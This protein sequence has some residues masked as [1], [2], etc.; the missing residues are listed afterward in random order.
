MILLFRSD[1]RHV[2]KNTPYTKTNCTSC[3]Y[4]VIGNTCK[5]NIKLL[6]NNTLEANFSPPDQP[7][8]KIDNIIKYVRY[9]PQSGLTNDS[10]IMQMATQTTNENVLFTDQHP[11]YMYE[12]KSEMDPTRHLQDSNDAT[13]ENFF[14]RPIKVAEAEWGT[15]TQL[16]FS[17]NPWASYFENKRV[18]NRIANYNLLRAKLNVK[19]VINGNGFQ[20]GRVLVN[21]LPLDTF[22]EASTS[23]GLIREDF[24]QAS[25]QPHVFLDPTTS[26]GG[27][28]KLPFFW[29]Q[30]YLSIPDADWN[31]M[32][33]LYFRSLNDLKHANGAQDKVTVS[34][35]VWATDVSMN[36]LTS[37]NPMGLV[38]QNGSEIDVANQKGIVSGPATAISK[39]S[40][41]LAVIPPIAPFALATSK[42]A[43]AV[44]GAAKALGYCRPPVTA[45]PAPMRIQPISS[46]AVTNVPDTALKLTVDEKQE[47]TIDPRIA[48]LGAE[49]PLSIREIAKRESY[50][51]TF[52]WAQGTAPETLL[53]NSRVDPVIWAE[54]GSTTKAYHFPACAM[55]AIPF[56]FWT[57][58]MNFRF[59]IVAS[60]FHKGRIKIVYDPVFI[61]SNEYNT[62]YLQVVD[63]SEKQDF[64]VS[65][66]NGQ[67][68][69]L[70]EHHNPGGDSA[71]Q[72]YS[73]TPY[74]F[75]DVGNGVVGVYIVNELTTPNS[76]VDNDIEINVFVSMGDDFEVFMPDNKFQ[77]FVFKPQAGYE[78]QQGEEIV[79]DS[80]NTE[81]P[82]APQQASSTDLGPGQQDNALINMVYTGESI[83]SFR[84]VLKRYNLHRSQL[85][86]SDIYQVYWLATRNMFPFYRG[87]IVGA[88]D[89]DKDGNS[90]NFC[91]TILLHWV[92]MAYQG[93]RGSIRTKLLLKNRKSSGGGSG[94]SGSLYVERTPARTVDSY[95][96]DTIRDAKVLTT[97]GQAGRASMYND[98][99]FDN[100]NTTGVRGMLFCDESINSNAEWENPYYSHLRFTP[101]KT[102]NL[103]TS[104]LDSEGYMLKYQGSTEATRSVDFHHAIGEDFQ[105]YMWTG[106]PRMYYESQAPNAT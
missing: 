25:Q 81:E 99:F 49:D 52:S 19:I 7:L 38:P 61:E 86:S 94:V 8:I 72:L 84:T 100:A 91:N 13:L 75:A 103:T 73:T 27:E 53:W 93:W 28:M 55:A 62:N 12:V 50:L 40:N 36:V 22:D 18:I 68:R 90:Y 3:L 45:N 97:N 6:N 96:S 21:Y 60:N 56:K 79:P 63:I 98:S 33:Q 2:N 104:Y 87:N 29:P 41:A 58:T 106:L 69:T 10:N 4:I 23:A 105:V 44:A 66:G 9:L 31:S 101:G 54:S 65:I 71:T 92:T 82:S 102:L 67:K 30:N 77:A 43:S 88:V 47:L 26:T 39:I 5:S 85:I 64:T 78:P 51:T 20:Y 46:L 70:L 17:I 95:Y 14:S 32:G 59:Q 11:H 24:V 74:T 83:M 57:G 34:V 76:S 42:V 89:D 80:Q 37:K 35:F 15:G 16:A 1:I 48:G